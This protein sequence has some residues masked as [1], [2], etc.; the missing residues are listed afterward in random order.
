MVSKI[1]YIQELLKEL[2]DKIDEITLNQK[3][4]LIDFIC[5]NQN[6]MSQLRQIRDENNIVESKFKTSFCNI[7]LSQINAV[8]AGD[9]FNIQLEKTTMMDLVNS[10]IDI[11]EEIYPLGTV[12]DLKREH[13]IKLNIDPSVKKVRMVIMQRFLPDEESKIYFPYAGIVYPV[14]NPANDKVLHFNQGLVEEV[15]HMGYTD[16]QEDAYVYLMKRVLIVEKKY[17]GI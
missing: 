5:N 4:I 14:G 2:L 6:N 9:N 13:L 1:N 7:D 16:E 8:F 12:V 3:N 17:R 11:T 10:I 15:V